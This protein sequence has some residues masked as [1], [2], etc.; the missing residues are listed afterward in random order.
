M[1]PSSG[2]NTHIC[3]YIYV[4]VCVCILYMYVNR[5]YADNIREQQSLHVAVLETKE[6]V[7]GLPDTVGMSRHDTSVIVSSNLICSSDC[8]CC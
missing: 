4:C 7:R 8:L 3:I 1:S 2:E 5:H 6:E